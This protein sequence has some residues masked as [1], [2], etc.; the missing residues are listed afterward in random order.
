MVDRLEIL[1][2]DT[3]ALSTALDAQRIARG[4]S[5]SQVAGQIHEL[6]SVL[7]NPRR[8][9]PISPSTIINMGRRGNISCQRA[10]FFL[11]WLGRSP[12]SFLH[13]S[14]SMG[15]PLPAADLVYAAVW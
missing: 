6:S 12:E 9:H 3:S 15:A 1:E 5:W 10:L 14:G 8:D 7:N 4:R 2:F 11:R 13:G